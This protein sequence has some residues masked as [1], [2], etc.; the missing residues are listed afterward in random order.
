MEST[1]MPEVKL[2]KSDIE[3]LV[4][5]CPRP[6]PGE[7]VFTYIPASRLTEAEKELNKARELLKECEEHAKRTSFQQEDDGW[8]LRAKESME[9]ASRITAFLGGKP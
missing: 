2:T 4:E 5:N 9:L 8:K 7:E 6:L 1:Q 3:E